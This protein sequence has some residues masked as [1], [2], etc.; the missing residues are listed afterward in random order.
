MSSQ[1]S[2]RQL[3]ADKRKLHI[4]E[5]SDQALLSISVHI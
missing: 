3:K 4:K 2:E 5:Q 1:V